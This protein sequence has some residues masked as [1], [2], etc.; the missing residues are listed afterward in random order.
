MFCMYSLTNIYVAI[1]VQDTIVHYQNLV[2]YLVSRALGKRQTILGKPFAECH[3]RQSRNGTKFN[4][5]VGFA[6]CLSS[7]TQ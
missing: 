1:T 4:S 5:K 6:E 3:I 2:L 7:D